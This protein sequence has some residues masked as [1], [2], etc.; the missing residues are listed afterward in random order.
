MHLKGIRSGQYY[1]K[2]VHTDASTE[3][4]MDRDVVHSAGQAEGRPSIDSL[5]EGGKPASSTSA[6]QPTQEAR[7]QFSWWGKQLMVYLASLVVMK[8]AILGFFWIP[9]VLAVG[10]W[11]LSW[12]GEDTKVI[13]VLMIFP[14]AMNAIQFL[15]IDTILKSSTPFSEVTA[16]EGQ[17]PA[18]TFSRRTSEDRHGRDEEEGRAFLLHD[19]THD[20]L[21]P[22]AK[23][24][25]PLPDYYEPSGSLSQN[26]K[27]QKHGS[28]SSELPADDKQGWSS[29]DAEEEDDDYSTTPRP[30]SKARAA[31]SADSSSNDANNPS[32]IPLRIVPSHSRR[33]SQDSSVG[34]FSGDQ[35]RESE[36]NEW[37]WLSDDGSTSRQN[38]QNDEESSTYERN[39]TQIHRS[40]PPLAKGS[41]AD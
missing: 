5:E 8:L 6:S 39:Q 40:E 29:F 22:G 35:R 23:D 34:G 14:L 3:E 31:S 4:A 38:D 18:S 7:F 24:A 21:D 16:V 11:M 32:A 12:L 17:G 19:T 33:A 36:P 9:A 37:D 25:T 30:G 2:Q 13:F 27:M 26:S 1:E 10:D 20:E 15:L 28:A 41:K